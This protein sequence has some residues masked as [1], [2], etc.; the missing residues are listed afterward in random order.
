M[1]LDTQGAVA[2]FSVFIDRKSAGLPRG[3]CGKSGK[4][5]QVRLVSIFISFVSLHLR[6]SCEKRMISQISSVI[7][8]LNNVFECGDNSSLALKLLQMFSKLVLELFG[9]P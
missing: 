1:A 3:T 8:E 2:G 5:T 7:Q 9:Q 6:R 4:V